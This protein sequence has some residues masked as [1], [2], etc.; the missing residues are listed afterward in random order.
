MDKPL[1]IILKERG[2]F[3]EEMNLC[4]YCTSCEELEKER[5]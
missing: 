2:E 5:K 1:A 3:E 4:N